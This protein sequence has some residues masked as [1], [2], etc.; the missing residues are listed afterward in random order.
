VDPVTGLSR[1]AALGLLAAIVVGIAGGTVAQ[2][3]AARGKPGCSDRRFGCATVEP[4]QPIQIGALF[5]SDGPGR[6]GV[7]A[8]ASSAETLFGHPLRVVGLDG[9]CSAQAATTA[10]REFA[11]DPP[12]GPPVVAVVGETCPAAEIPL[13]Q[14]LSDSGITFVSLAPAEVPGGASFYLTGPT[15]VVPGDAPRLSGAEF[16]AYE[17]TRFIVGAIRQVAVVH[18][19]DLLIPRTQLRDALLGTGLLRRASSAVTANG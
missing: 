8:V 4:D 19:D 14:I 5:P 6:L 13:A 11:T 9:S 1:R 12:D 10:A 3:V 16:R 2:Y 15:G 7:L 17:V 18:E